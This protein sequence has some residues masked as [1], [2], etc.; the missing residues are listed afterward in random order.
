MCIR[1][2]VGE[3]G[4]AS[5]NL[6]LV[7]DKSLVREI[8]GKPYTCLL[9][10]S[11]ASGRSYKERDDAGIHFRCHPYPQLCFQE[12]FPDRAM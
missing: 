3:G 5:G 6:S 2:R 4:G 12:A 8:V 9:Y 1:D 7:A 10:T 11:L